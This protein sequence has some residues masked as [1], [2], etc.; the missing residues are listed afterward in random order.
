MASAGASTSDACHPAQ[1][2]ESSGT[3]RSIRGETYSH[4]RREDRPISIGTPTQTRGPS[5]RRRVWPSAAR[6]FLQRT[7][8]RLLRQSKQTPQD[9]LIPQPRR[10]STEDQGNPPL[11]ELSDTS[12]GLGLGLS[13]PDSF[14]SL[15]PLVLRRTDDVAFSPSSF[16]RRVEEVRALGSSSGEPFA[17]AYPSSQRRPPPGARRRPPPPVDEVPTRAM[18]RLPSSLSRVHAPSRTQTTLRKPSTRTELHSVLELQALAIELDKLDP[19]LA[20]SPPLAPCLH[21]SPSIKS[22]HPRPPL[23]SISPQTALN[24]GCDPL[25]ELL[26]VADELKTMKNLDSEDILYI[27]DA[28]PASPLPPPL[29]AFFD[30]PGTSL[31]ILEMDVHREDET[32]LGVPIPC[33]VVTSE[34]D[35]LPKEEPE[36]SAPP[37]SSSED[38]LAPPPTTY[39][40]RVETDQPPII[41]E[42]DDER[43][44]LPSPS[45]SLA[46]ALLPRYEDSTRDK[47]EEHGGSLS[48]A[49]Y[50]PEC[51]LVD[52][53][54][55]W[56]VFSAVR[57]LAQSSQCTKPDRPTAPK[58]APL[59]RRRERSLLRRMLGDDECNIP[60]VKDMSWCIHSKRKRKRISK[61][62]IGSPR[63][64]SSSAAQ[65]TL[66]SPC[67]AGLR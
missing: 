7:L 45:P 30:V 36:V 44:P 28:P 1:S 51:S 43:S 46:P 13:G 49:C 41:A 12:P 56:E 39:R 42:G 66:L 62:T 9:G 52:G 23:Q 58:P 54:I 48:P 64:L 24:P 37:S 21:A 33:I 29:H 65:V 11:S 40:G 47:E 57:P 26:A 16:F 63:P 3:P 32:F 27:T 8:T 25:A 34:G 60:S 22:V 18:T 14:P 59:L 38:L 67:T 2:S 6:A 50:C 53:N 4:L 55:S 17:P 10:C 35:S 20:D 5:T 15:T 61:D 31:R 19:L